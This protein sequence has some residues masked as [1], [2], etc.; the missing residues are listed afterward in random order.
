MSLIIITSRQAFNAACLSFEKF[1]FRSFSPHSPPMIKE[2]IDFAIRAIIRPPRAF[3]SLLQLPSSIPLPGHDPVPRES[4]CFGNSRHHTLIG[5]YY[6]PPTPATKCVIYLHGNASFHCEGNFLIP[7]FIPAGV[8]VLCF[9]FS[10][11]GISGGE[12]ISLGHF[13]RDDVECAIEFV[14]TTFGIREIALWG[15]SMGAAT[16]VMMMGHPMIACAV[17]DSPFASLPRLLRE[18]SESVPIPGCLTGP[19][20][21][22]L[23]QKIMTLAH[24]DVRK[25]LPIEV[26][27]QGRKPLFLIH[28]DRDQLIHTEHSRRLKEAYGGPVELRIVS[29]DH[30]T[31]RPRRVLQDALGFLGGGLEV[32]L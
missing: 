31:D 2:V 6:A 19:A 9:D 30:T 16:A 24:F 32:P 25:V 22:F 3:Y 21:W 7:I 27:R 20:I 5:S 29:G 28:G 23:S 15:R 8:S 13:E 18:Q 1:S 10:G 12:Y 11:C 17:A 4:V 26:A 14:K